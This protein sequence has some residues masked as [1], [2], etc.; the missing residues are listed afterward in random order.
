M[1]KGNDICPGCRV[2]GTEKYR[3]AKNELCNEC[4]TSLK[5]GKSFEALQEKE[6]HIRMNVRWYS[7]DFFN[8]DNGGELID[9]AFRSLFKTLDVG[10]LSRGHSKNL[11]QGSA[12]TASETY[13]IREDIYE[14]L[15]LIVGALNTQQS[16][17]REKT[18]SYQDVLNKEYR[19]K[20]NDIYNDGI[21]KG[22]ELLFSLNNGDITMDDFNKKVIKY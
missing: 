11:T 17:F 18:K 12:T 10:G 7:L 9:K 20:K 19:D 14:S 21:I 6:K 16:D 8:R 15:L 4:K 13:T 5:V 22:R 3:E 1:Y 2:P